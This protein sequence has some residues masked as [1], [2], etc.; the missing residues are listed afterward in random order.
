MSWNFHTPI[1]LSLACW[2]A[3]SSASADVIYVAAAAPP[4]GDGATWATAYQFVA[5]ALTAAHA[6]DEIRVAQGRYQP[7]QAAAHPAGTQARAATFFLPSGVR[8]RGGFAGPGAPDPNAWS[9]AGFPTELAGDQAGDDTD[10]YFENFTD[11]CYHVVTIEAN[12]LQS[13]RLV[14]FR[15]T[16]ARADG[17]GHDALGGGL[18]AEGGAA[19]ITDCYFRDNFAFCGSGIAC[20]VGDVTIARCVFKDSRGDR[21]GGVLLRGGGQPSVH[22]SHFERVES[23][24]GAGILVDQGTAA[25][26]DDCTFLNAKCDVIGNISGGGVA[27]EG[28][29]AGI[30]RCR[31]LGNKCNGGGGGVFALNN[32]VATVWNCAFVDNRGQFDGGDQLFVWN[33][34]ATLVNCTLLRNESNP[35]GSVQAF[36][37]DGTLTLLNCTVLQRNPA[38]RARGIGLQG[39]AL[40]AHNTIIW[41]HRAAGLTHETAQ[42]APSPFFESQL[43]IRWSTIDGWTGDLG[44]IGNNSDVP[45][46]VA[47]EQAILRL[48]ANS[49]LI[50]AGDAG[51]LP[52]DS[53]DLDSDANLAEPVPVDFFGSS[54]RRDEPATP[55]SGPG[56][57]PIIDRGAFEFAPWLGDC[58]G[59]GW[60]NGDDFP[61][62]DSCLLG[63]AA[64]A[65]QCADLDLDT[66]NDL[67]D[68]ALAQSRVGR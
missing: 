7:D 44:G 61:L 40:T 32:A 51:L 54:R 58:D 50:D 22:S 48:A 8:L 19:S 41:G 42:I 34:D 43:D 47:A 63:P 56:S 10:D 17:P 2:L 52:P 33:A 36:V 55:D 14:G 28:A 1:A 45:E 60:I 65:C 46:F 59:N 31:F 64:A 53:P 15:I 25:R 16:G 6:G 67:H 29:S 23:G 5:D 3:V 24:F 12:A 35:F 66:D 39:G 37:F 13:T 18:L 9:P 38:D 62:L 68:F 20:L 4:G 49:P 11:N 26:I 21:G 30:V 57:P 27:V